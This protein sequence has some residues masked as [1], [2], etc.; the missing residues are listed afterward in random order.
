MHLVKSAQL[1]MVCVYMIEKWSKNYSEI[2]DQKNLKLVTLNM[3]LLV[4]VCTSKHWSC[5]KK[6]EKNKPID[7]LLKMVI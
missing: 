2:F 5:E 6:S 1:L 7:D 4:I 3:T